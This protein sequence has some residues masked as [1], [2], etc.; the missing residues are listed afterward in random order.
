M[1]PNRDPPR[2]SRAGAGEGQQWC[3]AIVVC[4]VSEITSQVK[5]SQVSLFAVELRSGTL[6]VPADA[7]F[8]TQSTTVR[9]H[10]PTGCAHDGH[11]D[12]PAHSACRSAFLLSEARPNTE[13]KGARSLN[14]PAYRSRRRPE[15]SACAWLIIIRARLVERARCQ[16]YVPWPA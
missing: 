6:R 14:C 4:R 13:R 5:S 3:K 12:R 7:F 2:R 16:R 11:A 8:R 1:N 9:S 10:R 15:Q